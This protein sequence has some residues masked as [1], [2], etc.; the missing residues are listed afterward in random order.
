MSVTDRQ[1]D[2]WTNSRTAFVCSASR[3]KSCVAM[4]SQLSWPEFVNE[5]DNYHCQTE[6][7]SEHDARHDRQQ[8]TCTRQHGHSAIEHCLL[9]ATKHL[10]NR[11]V[12]SNVMIGTC[13]GN[14]NSLCRENSWTTL[15]MNH[16][17]QNINTQQS[18]LNTFHFSVFINIAICP[19][20]RLICIDWNVRL[21]G[22]ISI[23]NPI[24]GI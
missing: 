16:Q 15:F 10:N 3:G 23:L 24:L 19:L 6:R 14:C 1:T 2:G 5:G 20:L 12:Q 17:H 11:S 21:S 22:I 8:Q 9:L 13:A 18:R 7:H 4:Y